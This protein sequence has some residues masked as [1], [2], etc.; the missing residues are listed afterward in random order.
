MDTAK[1]YEGNFALSQLY[2]HPPAKFCFLDDLSHRQCSA[3]GGHVRK[4]AIGLRGCAEAV[5]DQVGFIHQEAEVVG[6]QLHP[7]GRLAV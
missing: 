1:P 4:V 2:S 6:L 7:A 5:T 3:Y